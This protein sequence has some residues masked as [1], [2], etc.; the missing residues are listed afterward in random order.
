MPVAGPIAQIIRPFLAAGCLA[1]L[2]GPARVEAQASESIRELFERDF[3][4]AWQARDASA[5]A[6]LWLPDG[7]WSNVVG[8]RRVVQGTAA[9]QEVWEVGLRG[10]STPPELAIEIAVDHIRLLD[11]THAVVDLVMT[12]APAT[13]GQIREAF[14]MIVVFVEGDW[15][16][17]AARAARISP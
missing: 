3:V 11:S 16:V 15:R 4:E 7:D 14:V 17:A 2:A 10:R 5:I 9:L 13:T 6:R 1:A 12:F 8:S